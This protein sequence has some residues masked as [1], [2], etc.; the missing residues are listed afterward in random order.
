MNKLPEFSGPFREVIIDFISY[1]RSLGYT[2]LP[3]VIYK[4]REM[5]LFFKELGVENI[6]ITREM[7]EKWTAKKPGEKATTT[8][9]RKSVVV[10]IAKYLIMMG[11]SDIYTGFD[12]T[13][14]FHQDFIPYIFSDAEINRMLC[15]L[16]ERCENEPSYE[17]DAFQLIILMYYCCGFRKSEVQKLKVKDVDFETGKITIHNG[18]NQVSRIVVISDSLF[19]KMKNFQKCHLE[20]CLPEDI[21]FHGEKSKTYNSNRLYRRFHDLLTEAKIPCRPDGGRQRIH[22]LRHKFSI[23][24]LEKMQEKGFDLYTSLP[25]LSVYLGHKSITETEY[26]LRMMEDHFNGILKLAEQ[27]SP[28]LFPKGGGTDES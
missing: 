18:K 1:K 15:I 12:D 28:D 23:K 4:L 6:E 22:D 8:E 24:T 19:L 10:G 3:P 14:I 16:A 26:Y 21:L 9:K 2:F 7:Y 11:Y 17:N 13:R 20:Q 5:D 25:L 27:Y